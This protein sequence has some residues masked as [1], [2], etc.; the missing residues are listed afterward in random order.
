MIA[1]ILAVAITGFIVWIITQIPM[2]V[3]FKNIIYGVVA[4]CLVIW[5][6]QVLG[7]HTG[8]P[9]LNMGSIK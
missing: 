2:P 9:H 5:L 3:I 7:F 1:I 4:I 8:F 6:L